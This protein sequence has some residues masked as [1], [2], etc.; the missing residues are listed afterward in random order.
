M[1]EQQIRTL[2]TL[3]QKGEVDAKSELVKLLSPLV[4]AFV[5]RLAPRNER[6]DLYQV[7]IIGLLK[8]AAR[9][10]LKSSARFTTYAV[11]WIQGEMKQYRRTRFSPVKISRC[12][13]E[14]WL[15]LEKHRCRLTN[16]LGRAPSL[17]E[18]G[19][20][21]G[22]SPEEITL[23]LEAAQ[24]VIPLSEDALPLPEGSTEETE[25][26]DRISLYE[27]ISRLAPLERALIKLRF[28]QERTQEETA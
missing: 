24:P 5:V 15:L 16:Q 17:S 25:L 27:G 6:E 4:M 21:A 14:Q 12:L 10:D 18:L 8:A 11:P 26:V 20:Q 19:Q 1:T 9:F 2:V 28:F 22:F 23:I 13:W 7:G 3:V